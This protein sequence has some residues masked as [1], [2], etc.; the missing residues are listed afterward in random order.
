MLS[1]SFQDSP[2][3]VLYF[4]F[5]VCSVLRGVCFG[6]VVAHDSGR[7]SF[8]ERSDWLLIPLLAAEEDE[9]GGVAEILAKQIGRFS[10]ANPTTRLCYNNNGFAAFCDHT[11]VLGPIGSR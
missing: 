7:T 11:W 9:D 10:A 1:R 6:L 8:D 3:F 4:G 5:V 2:T